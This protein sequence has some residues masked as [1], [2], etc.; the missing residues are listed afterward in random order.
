MN[1]FTFASRTIS[2]ITLLGH[3]RLKPPFHR[4]AVVLANPVE[5]FARHAANHPVVAEIRSAQ[6]AGD[7]PSQVSLRRHQRHLQPV[8]SPGHRGNHAARRP[9]INHEIELPARA[10]GRHRK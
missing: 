5:Y 2:F 1:T 6:P 3:M 4:F 7:H 8:A 10:A 9:A